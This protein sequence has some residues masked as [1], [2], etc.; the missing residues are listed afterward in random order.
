MKLKLLILSLAVSALVA[1][2]STDKHDEQDK[3]K[4][5]QVGLTLP[6]P[7]YVMVV[8][9]RS[10]WRVAPENSLA[11]VQACINSSVDMVEVDVRRTKDGHLV[12][13]HDESVDRTTNGS[14]LVSN[15]TLEEVQ[16]LKLRNNDGGKG[17][18]ITEQNIPTLADLFELAKGKILINLDVKQ[19]VREQAIALAN[20]MGMLNQILVKMTV[21]KPKQKERALKMDFLKYVAFMPIIH[22]DGIPPGRKINSLQVLNPVAFEV[23]FKTDTFLIATAKAAH[24]NHDL[25]WVNTMWERLS[26]GH[27]DDIAM[28]NPDAHW[29][30]LI[31]AGANIIQTDRPLHLIKYL[32]QSARR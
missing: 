3:T 9:H 17:A 22:Q 14:G 20:E 26:P 29:G 28:H 16:A 11:A 4:D 15:M 24:Q 25:V 23:V 7:D 18:E 21:D 6:H 30:H 12:V 2:A 5:S 10:C 27:S 32:K 1:C 8:A 31:R 19:D 13:L